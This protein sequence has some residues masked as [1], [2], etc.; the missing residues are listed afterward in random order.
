MGIDNGQRLGQRR[1]WHVVV[2]HD[3]VHTAPLG[4][5]YGVMGGDARIAS[6][7]QA[8][9]LRGKAVDGGSMHS[10]SFLACWDV[11]DDIG[12]QAKK[13]FQEYCC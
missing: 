13:A 3:H 10:V 6:E 8:G 2:C 12:F 9:A 1:G 11:V 4:M 5:G 7:D